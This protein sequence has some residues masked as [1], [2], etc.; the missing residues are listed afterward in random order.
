MKT[1]EIQQGLTRRQALGGLVALG[2]AASAAR[3]AK[4]AQSWG[5]VFIF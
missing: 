3:P 2:A 1:R 4:S 5:R